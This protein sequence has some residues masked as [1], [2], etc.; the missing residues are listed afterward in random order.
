MVATFVLSTAQWTNLSNHCCTP[1]TDIILCVNYPQKKKKK[2][3][4][5][6]KKTDYIGTY[7]KLL[8]DEGTLPRIKDSHANG[9][10]AF[11]RGPNHLI[12]LFFSLTQT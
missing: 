11:P 9:C 10:F 2:K 3:K 8:E 5:K 6:G 4:G 12:Q 1:A 7:S